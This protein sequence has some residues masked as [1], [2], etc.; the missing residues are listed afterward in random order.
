[1]FYDITGVLFLALIQVPSTPG[2]LLDRCC[3]DTQRYITTVSRS[4]GL[5][6]NQNQLQFD[7]K[8]AYD[9][10]CGIYEGSILQVGGEAYTRVRFIRETVG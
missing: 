8:H 1:M 6:A 2:T 7:T 4:Q 9:I 10:G 5:Y 3:L